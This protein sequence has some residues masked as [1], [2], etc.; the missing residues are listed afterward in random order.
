MARNA[1][2]L[3]AESRAALSAF[4][5]DPS[6]CVLYVF[7]DKQSGNVKA[8]KMPPLAESCEGRVQYFFKDSDANLEGIPPLDLLQQSIFFGYLRADNAAQD[9]TWLVGQLC[10]P[11]VRHNQACP[12]SL[13][14]DLVSS[15]ERFMGNMTDMANLA[16][17]PMAI[18][19][20]C[21]CV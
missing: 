8:Q 3:R 20:V 15:L 14:K 18:G 7:I 9:L 12:A 16:A 13:S 11:Q 10:L 21:A 6:D 1:V 2:P 17:G 19:S 5:S 4:F